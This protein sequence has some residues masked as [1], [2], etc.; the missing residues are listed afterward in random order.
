MTS[1]PPRYYYCDSKNFGS[2]NGCERD[3]IARHP[4]LPGRLGQADIE[5][6]LKRQGMSWERK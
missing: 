1:F 6:N 5:Y 4:N 3:I 2:V